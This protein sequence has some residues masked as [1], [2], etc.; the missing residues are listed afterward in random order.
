MSSDFRA[1]GS[2]L[3]ETILHDAVLRESPIFARLALLW[4]DAGRMVPGRPDQE[5]RHLT[6]PP[7][8][9]RLGRTAVA[10]HPG[11]DA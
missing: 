6:E 4:L 5:W 1:S 9:F 8:L 7:Q 10:L 3:D 11:E 2:A